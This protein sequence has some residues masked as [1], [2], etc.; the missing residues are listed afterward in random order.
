[1]G[2]SFYTFLSSFYCVINKIIKRLTIYRS[3][4]WLDLLSAAFPSDDLRSMQLP[5][6]DFSACPEV[7]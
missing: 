7:S 4:K 6:I 3:R 5:A 2:S 1:M